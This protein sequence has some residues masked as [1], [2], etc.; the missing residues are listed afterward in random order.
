MIFDAL[1]K[2]ETDAALIGPEVDTKVKQEAADLYDKLT[3]KAYLE[4]FLS[5]IQVLANISQKA[6]IPQKTL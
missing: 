6:P 5:M 1:Q 4:K 2:Q 3:E